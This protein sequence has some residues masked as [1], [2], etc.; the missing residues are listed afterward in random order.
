MSTPSGFGMSISVSKV[1]VPG[2]SVGD[3]RHCAGK[4]AIGDL[5]NLQR[6]LDPGASRTP[7][8]GARRLRAD[9]VPLHDREHESAAGRIGLNQA[10]DI[11]VALRD[12]AVERS[13]DLLIGLLLSEHAQLLLLGIHVGLRNADRC[14]LGLEC[15]GVD[16]ALLLGVPAL[17]DQRLV[18]VPRYLR[19][20]RIRLRLLQRRL[21]LRERCLGLQ[22]LV[23]EF[24]HGNLGQ[25]LPLLDAIP[26]VDLRAYSI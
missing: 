17:L 22:D 13:D 7:G 4:G 1:R 9:N 16:S 14:L 3:P 5:G 19:Q 2:C 12:D 15:L 18:A 11:D 6:G 10:A 25:Q 8:P 20:L 21:E 26:D 24:R 23:V